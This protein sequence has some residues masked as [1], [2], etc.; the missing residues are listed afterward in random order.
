VKIKRD[1]DDK[2]VQKANRYKY[3]HC[4][5]LRLKLELTKPC[6]NRSDRTI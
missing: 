3:V 1:H 2:R 5:K 6:L 4:A